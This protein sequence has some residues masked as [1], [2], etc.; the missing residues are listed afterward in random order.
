MVE[1]KREKMELVCE[2]KFVELYTDYLT[3]PGGDRV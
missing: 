2:A 3:T 1:F